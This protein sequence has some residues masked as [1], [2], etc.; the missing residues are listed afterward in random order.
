MSKKLKIIIISIVSSIVLIGIIVGIVLGVVLGGKKEADYRTI[1]VFKTEGTAYVLRN[2]QREDC[3]VDLKLKSNDELKTLEE[4]NVV[5]KLDED[6][7]IYVG[8]KSNI[9]VEATKEK[10]KLVISEGSIVSEVKNKLADGDSF[11]VDTPNTS[12]TIRGTNFGVTVKK[13]NGQTQITYKL[14]KGLIDVNVIQPKNGAFDISKFSLTPGNGFTIKANDSGLVDSN[15]ISKVLEDNKD[16]IKEYESVEEYVSVNGD[17]YITEFEMDEDDYKEILEK[18]VG[19]NL[20]NMIRLVSIN[21]SFTV[22]GTNYNGIAL[23]EADKEFNV[24]LKPKEIDGQKFDYWLINGEKNTNDELSLTISSNTTIEAVYIGEEIWTVSFETNSTYSVKSVKVVNGKKI[25]L[26]NKNGF[27]P[28]NGNKIYSFVG[29]YTDQELTQ[30][31]D[32]ETL[33]T[34]DI[35]LYAK[36]DETTL[37]NVSVISNGN[38]SVYIDGEEL[39]E[40]LIKENDKVKITVDKIE[41]GYYF[42]GYFDDNNDLLTRNLSYEITV[43][44]DRSINA[45]FGVIPDEINVFYD[46][47]E[48]ESHTFMTGTSRDKLF[49]NFNFVSKN[50]NDLRTTNITEYNLDSFEKTYY[51]ASSGLEQISFADIDT[52]NTENYYF[53]DFKLINTN[54]TTSIGFNFVDR[55]DEFFTLAN[56]DI[57][58]KLTIDG[59]YNL[60]SDSSAG[61]KV[62]NVDAVYNPKGALETAESHNI[63]ISAGKNPGILKYLSSNG[64][65]IIDA[66]YQA[67]EDYYLIINGEIVHEGMLIPTEHQLIIVEKE[68]FGDKDFTDSSYLSAEDLSALNDNNHYEIDVHIDVNATIK[69]ETNSNIALS[70][71]IVGLNNTSNVDIYNSVVRNTPTKNPTDKYEYEFAGWYLDKDLTILFEEPTSY[72]DVIYSDMTLYAKY[73]ETLRKY[74]LYVQGNDDAS[75]EVI[76]GDEEPETVYG[77]KYSRNFSIEYGT[78]VV[79]RVSEI[80][81]SDKKITGTIINGNVSDVETIGFYSFVVGDSSH[82]SSIAFTLDYN[83]PKIHIGYFDLDNSSMVNFA[84]EAD[85]EIGDK[86]KIT[87]ALPESFTEN[88]QYFIGYYQSFYSSEGYTQFSGLISSDINYEY[89][90]I[91]NGGVYIYA[92]YCNTPTNE[93]DLDYK[94][95]ANYGDTNIS[96]EGARFMVGDDITTYYEDMYAEI[97]NPDTYNTSYIYIEAFERTYRDSEGNILDSFD[98]KN[99]PLGS[100]SVEFKLLNSTSDD[101]SK[102]FHFTV[103]DKPYFIL[104]TEIVDKDSNSIN[105]VE[106]RR[107]PFIISESDRE[108][109]YNDYNGETEFSDNNYYTIIYDADD[110]GSV[111]EADKQGMNVYRLAARTAGMRINTTEGY[112][113]YVGDR[114]MTNTEHVDTPY[115]EKIDDYYE[116]NYFTLNSGENVYNYCWNETVHSHGQYGFE[117][118][119]YVVNDNINVATIDG[120]TDQYSMAEL[121]DLYE[122]GHAYKFRLII[123]GRDVSDD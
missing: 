100:Y 94:N 52:S 106:Y 55:P 7:F 22:E 82:T 9:K 84:D 23:Y 67:P 26:S 25:D 3:Y 31:F 91:K 116:Y 18:N 72:Y 48:I 41:E 81:D 79:V 97:Y 40:A 24:K 47:T 122:N 21:S 20:D 69:F 27:K 38:A 89:E 107:D 119:L 2:E 13:V 33:I 6:K 64:S 43:T 68:V 103:I 29:W 80:K 109:R 87:S 93:M 73:N 102:T 86:V 60:T 118:T 14:I 12:M 28:Q 56:D 101:Y 63:Y 35:T 71:M 92:I 108:N 46:L 32:S 17:V 66:S 121:E 105:Y 74:N 115:L 44:E 54:L 49:D 98:E 120:S 123:I 58:F 42:L 62:L 16:N 65:Y 85:Y 36:Y 95:S 77:N 11:E 70:D 45:K 19:F 114:L 34:K 39:N 112:T 4:S 90:V 96:L 75:I 1:K 5:L 99:L 113:L 83:T 111:E 50:N 15:N 110:F 117:L 30:E 8:E 59:N 104:S 57:D 37:Y 88:A 51:L 10:F 78:E 61:I 53:A 76:I